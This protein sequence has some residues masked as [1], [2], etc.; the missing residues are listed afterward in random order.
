M[1]KQF[2][3]N[4]EKLLVLE[5]HADGVYY[6]VIRSGPNQLV[7]LTGE[8]EWLALL[9]TVADM[10]KCRADDNHQSTWQDVGDGNAIFYVGKSLYLTDA[11]NDRV[12][13]VSLTPEDVDRIEQY[14]LTNA[15]MLV[16]ALLT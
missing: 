3:G 16:E 5:A 1:S 13:E 7:Q 4:D 9:M 2:F 11:L 8:M 6:E 15:R 10:K 12:F 14:V